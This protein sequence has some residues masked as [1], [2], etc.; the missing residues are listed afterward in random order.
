VTGDTRRYVAHVATSATN[1]IARARALDPE[2]VDWLVA[3]CLLIASEL[4]I[5]TQASVAARVGAAI[6][7]AAGCCALAVRRRWLLQGLGLALVSLAVLLAASGSAVLHPPGVVS[8]VIGSLTAVL[9]F[10]AGGAFLEGWRS[11]LALVLGAAVLSVSAAAAGSQ[12]VANLIWDVAIIGLLPWFIGRMMRER[13]AHGRAARRRA[14][15][16]DS[17][18][19]Y[20]ARAAALGE[21]AR[22]AREIHDVIAHSVSVMVIQAAGARTVMD[23]EPDRAQEAL[24]SVERAGREALAEMRR[25][26]GVLGDGQHMRELAPQP[27]IEDLD[28]LVSRTRKAGLPASISVVGEPISVAPGLS[29][30]AYR[31]VQEALTN[32]IKHAGAA[33][34]EV[35]V[36]WGPDALELE[37]IDNGSAAG[38]GAA[39]PGGHGLVGMR[40]RAALH[41]GSVEAGPGPAGGFVVRARI[42]LADRSVL[43]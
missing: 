2:R 3:A 24:L 1:V 32:A 9:L 41:G 17:Q 20:H 35:S 16:L 14:E 33:R 19:E 12:F 37:V 7:A 26:L 21:R 13:A 6:W 38:D 43:A 42:P 36:R 30:C 28:E 23:R 31:V 8:G 10:Y 27:G 39:A 18:R 15:L 11:R 25:L 4:A 22:L 40:E 34:A 29:L 5:W